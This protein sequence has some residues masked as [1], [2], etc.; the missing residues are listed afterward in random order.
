M[1]YLFVYTQFV[2]F[3]I[4]IFSSVVLWQITGVYFFLKINNT[5]FCIN[6]ILSLSLLWLMNTYVASVLGYLH[7]VAVN[8]EMQLRLWHIALLLNISSLAKLPDHL[9][10]VFFIIW[11][12]SILFSIRS[13]L[14]YIPNSVKMFPI[15]HMPLSIW[16]LYL[17]KIITILTRVKWYLTV[18]LVCIC[19]MIRI[20]DF[21]L[22]GPNTQHL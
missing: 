12:N 20:L 21:C 17:F 1:W 14:I 4:V 11:G 7:S 8:S 9:I 22:L 5:L 10:V 15:L 19:L 3:S 13:I 6:S 2:S 16:H 18:V